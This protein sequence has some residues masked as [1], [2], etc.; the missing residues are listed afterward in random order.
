[1]SVA[2]D[3][4]V[5]ERHFTLDKGDIGPD[6]FAS[7]TPVEFQAYVRKIRDAEIIMGGWEKRIMPEEEE[8]AMVSKKSVA[9]R[10][11]KKKGEMLEES[12]LIL[13][14]P[15]IGISASFAHKIV[16]SVLNRDVHELEHIQFRDLA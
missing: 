10:V 11:A 1:M 5:I 7:S 3:A 4:R 16:G 15:N 13:L 6:H 2:L 12:D 14:R 8:M 9:L